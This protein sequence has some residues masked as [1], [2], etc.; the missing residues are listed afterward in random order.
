V[1]RAD[2]YPYDAKRRI[3][4]LIETLRRL[5]DRDPEQEVQGIALPVLDAV[6]E[7]V[8]DVLAGDPVMAA[9]RSIISVEQIESGEPIRAADALLAAEQIDAAIGPYPLGGFA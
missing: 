6:I 7:S 5:T 3:G 9:V 8:R 2:S 1:S 4:A